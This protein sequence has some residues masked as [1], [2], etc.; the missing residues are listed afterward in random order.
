VTFE[1]WAEQY[2]FH[3]ELIDVH[4]YAKEAARDAWQASRRAAL[5]EA[6]KVCDEYGELS[7]AEKDSALLVGKIE[8]SNAM[9]GEPR[10]AEFL[11]NAIRALA[12]EPT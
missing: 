8:L 1:K 3:A 6:A 11:A 10:A 5:E 7:A 9:S 2:G 4:Q 12:K